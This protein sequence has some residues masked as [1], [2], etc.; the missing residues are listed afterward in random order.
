[1]IFRRQE[2]AAVDY[3]AGRH[4]RQ[5]KRNLRLLIVFFAIS[6]AFFLVLGTPELW[7]ELELRRVGVVVPAHVTE[8]NVTH[9]RGGPGYDVRYE[10]TVPGHEERLTR[11][12]WFL[13]SRTNLWSS[14]D[15]AAWELSKSTGSIEVTYLPDHP[16][17][18]RPV[19]ATSGFGNTIGV[20]TIGG[21]AWIMAFLLV[22]VRRGGRLSRMVLAQ[23]PA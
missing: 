23:P 8:W 19:D 15:V 20:V 14:L 22:V 16:Q 21:I 18:N 13:L 1:M 7:A 11:A 4:H 17:I 9:G 3:V 2:Q 10:L 12:D 5:Q 6:G